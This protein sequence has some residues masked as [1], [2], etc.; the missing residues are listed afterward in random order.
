MTPGFKP[1]TTCLLV[2]KKE[3]G[4]HFQVQLLC[5][6]KIKKNGHA[7]FSLSENLF[8]FFF[9]RVC[10]AK[11]MISESCWLLFQLTL[12]QINDCELTLTTVRTVK[13]PIRTIK[14]TIVR[15]NGRN[16]SQQCCVPLHGVKSL[17]GG[18]KLCATTPN[19]TQQHATGCA[20]GRNM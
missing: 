7:L 3:L 8:L 11:K 20:N 12:D 15:E 10:N 5:H 13:D 16:N 4:H 14:A 18:F 6:R 2:I 1:F 9:F 17:T 19:N